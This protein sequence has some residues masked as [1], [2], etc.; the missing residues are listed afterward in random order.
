MYL[1]YLKSLLSSGQV[2][3]YIPQTAGSTLYG[4]AEKSSSLLLPSRPRKIRLGRG[5]GYIN[6]MNTADS[7]QQN[8]K[9]DFVDLTT[10]S[11]SSS[12]YTILNQSTGASNSG[13]AGYTI[14]GTNS[15]GTAQ[16]TIQKILFSNDT[17]S[18]SGTTL[19]GS[20]RIFPFV[21]NNQVAGYAMGS[22]LGSLGTSI[23]KINFS[24]DARTTLSATTSQARYGDGGFSNSGT[25]GYRCF[26]EA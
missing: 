5:K 20:G 10:S 13:T 21:S 25:A 23:D 22:A 12:L 16:T 1:G 17:T 4:G 3:Q 7:F 19:S 9:L 15:G 26:G 11:L 18:V 24:T 6:S 2:S 8:L 14:G